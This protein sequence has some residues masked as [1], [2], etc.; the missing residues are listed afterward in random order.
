MLNAYASLTI[1]CQP[2]R[3]PGSRAIGLDWGVETFATI[4]HE[5]AMFSAI[6][7]PRFAR[8]ARAALETAQRNFAN[9]AWRLKNRGEGSPPGLSPSGSG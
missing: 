5:D 6:E 4:A 3:R 8:Q 7:N 2:K 9:P 1:A